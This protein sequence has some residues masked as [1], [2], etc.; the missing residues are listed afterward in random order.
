MIKLKHILTEAT[1]NLLQTFPIGSKNF[2]VGY[3]AGMNEP[4]THLNRDTVIQNSDYGGGDAA[5]RSRGGHLGI[6]IF[7]PKGEPVVAPVT[8]IV[9]KVSHS[10]TGAGGKSV[11]I[12][13]NGISFYH[14]HLDQAYVEDGQ[15]VR[16]GQ[17]IGTCGDTGNAAGTHPHVH[18]S[19]YRTKEGYS[20]GSINPWP[21]LQN[22]MYN[23][24]KSDK[25]L[26]VLH[27]K[28]QKLG[29]DLGDEQ[30][31]GINGP[32][33]QAALIKLNKTYNQKQQS[34]G[35]TSKIA[36]FLSGIINSDIA[37]SV[38]GNKKPE[39][40]PK[41]QNHDVPTA[42]IPMRVISFFKNKGLTTSQA[43]G[44][45]GNMSIEST[46]KP[47][48]VGDN[49]TSYG[50]VQWHADRWT[51]LKQYCAKNNL[52]SASVE[53]QLEFLWYE[54][55]NNSGLGYTNLI[56]QTNPRD[57]AEVFAKHFERPTHISPERMNNAEKYYNEYTK[58]AADKIA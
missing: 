40:K 28:L 6:D 25:N 4:K 42:D 32:K 39:N 7:A 14:A 18:F 26:D 56:Q 1:D 16:A 37:Q 50:L 30:K 9:I 35:F 19:I 49:G 12:D 36:S 27:K 20:R 48:V 38:L 10:D 51:N 41:I 13:K 15:E 53:G 58:H 57:A 23:V 44:I 22:V 43:S 5:H 45:A 52:D 55:K 8:G 29:F 17:L 21:S 47:D 46:F 24:T 34:G 3:D 54:L 2:N 33:T 31:S 11:T